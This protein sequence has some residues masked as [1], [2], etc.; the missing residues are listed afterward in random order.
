MVYGGSP[1][2]S[3]QPK[4]ALLVHPSVGH[5]SALNITVCLSE[6]PSDISSIISLPRCISW[7]TYAVKLV[8]GDFMSK[9]AAGYS[10]Q[11]VKFKSWIQAHH[12][13]SQYILL[14]SINAGR[15]SSNMN[16]KILL[17]YLFG[18]TPYIFHLY[19]C[20]S[21]SFIRKRNTNQLDNIGNIPI[22]IPIG[23]GFVP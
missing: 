16:I 10:V 19:N 13:N 20:Y 1:H 22:G 4:P 15:S 8:C 2:G 9:F 11:R 18:I 12:Q 23:I 7:W 5:S 14:K 3:R 21:S 17:L 6:V